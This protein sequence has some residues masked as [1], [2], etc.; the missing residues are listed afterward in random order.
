MRTGSGTWTRGSVPCHAGFAMYI[1]PNIAVFAECVL[2]YCN[3]LKEAMGDAAEWLKTHAP[4]D[5]VADDDE[6]VDEEGNMIDA[7][8]EFFYSPPPRAARED[9]EESAGEPNAEDALVRAAEDEDRQMQ[10]LWLGEGGQEDGREQG[11]DAGGEEEAHEELW[12]AQGGDTATEVD[13]HW[14]PKDPPS[15]TELTMNGVYVC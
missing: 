10:D 6:V 2:Q 12:L 13:P 1:D 11:R 8:G 15:G 5:E 7:D 4:A 14:S 9:V 3:V